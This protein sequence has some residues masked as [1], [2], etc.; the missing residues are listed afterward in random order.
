MSAGR[1][2]PSFWTGCGRVLSQHVLEEC[3]PGVLAVLQPGRH[4][5]P[6]HC[7][8]FLVPEAHSTAAALR[9]SDK[10]P[11]G[12]CPHGVLPGGWGGV[13]VLKG[14]HCVPLKVQVISGAQR[15]KKEAREGP[16]SPLNTHT[17]THR[18][19]KDTCAPVR[20]HT[21]TSTGTHVC[22]QA[23]CAPVFT[24]TQAHVFG[25]PVPTCAFTDTHT[26]I[27]VGRGTLGVARG[28]GPLPS[29]PP[30]ASG[31]RKFFRTCKQG[32]LHFLLLP[33][34]FHGGARPVLMEAPSLE[35]VLGRDRC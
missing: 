4:P 5:V 13:Q 22:P 9:A 21:H 33:R 28:L 15:Q 19:N 12:G 26:R 7:V 30:P 27:R 14:P 34:T 35:L 31:P 17:H 3:S 20:A 16:P 10:L 18:I 24:N 8:C 23:Q 11:A 25:A 32:T 2:P 1:A 29:H 6:G